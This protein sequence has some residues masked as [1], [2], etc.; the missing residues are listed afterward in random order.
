MNDGIGVLR[1][2]ADA[3]QIIEVA[4]TALG[5]LGLQGRGRGVGAGQ[6]DDVM[7]CAQQLVYR[8]GTDPA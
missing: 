2:G 5:A 8:G 3:V 1:S 6:A 4:A 7:T